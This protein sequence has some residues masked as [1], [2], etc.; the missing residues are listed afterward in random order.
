MSDLNYLSYL[1]LHTWMHS[2]TSHYIAMARHKVDLCFLKLKDNFHL[3]Y[4]VLALCYSLLDHLC[5]TF[6]P[7]YQ[8]RTKLMQAKQK[9]IWHSHICLSYNFDSSCKSGTLQVITYNCEGL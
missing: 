4:D 9:L 7:K 3:E 2:C 5:E 6:L 1:H 8:S